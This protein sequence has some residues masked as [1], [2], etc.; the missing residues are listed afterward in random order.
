MAL[1]TVWMKNKPTSHSSQ[2]SVVK[3]ITTWLGEKG[4]DMAGNFH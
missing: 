2:F 3:T 1:D 4:G